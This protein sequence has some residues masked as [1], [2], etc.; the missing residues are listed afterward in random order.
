[1]VVLAALLFCALPVFGTDWSVAR[2]AHFE[3]YAQAGEENARWMLLGLE[4]LHAFVPEA[5]PPLQDHPPVRVLVFASPEEYEPYRIG[6]SSDAFYIGSE[7]RDTIVMARRGPGDLRVAAHEY[8][9]VVEHAAGRNLPPWLNEGLAEFFSTVRLEEAHR[10]SIDL[11]A[12]TRTLRTR[13]WLPVSEL[14]ALSADSVRASNRGVSDRF[15]AQSWALAE[16]LLFA[17]RY[18]PRFPDLLAAVSAGA[19]G[20]EAFAAIYGTPLEEVEGD[21]RVWIGHRRVTPLSIPPI[22][23]HVLTIETATV[24]PLAARSLLAE[25]LLATSRFDRAWEVYRELAAQAPANPD[26]SA[27]LAL[28]ELHN[29]HHADARRQWTRALENGI[30]DPEVCYRFALAAQNAELAVEDIRPALARAVELRPGFDDAL[31]QLGL[32]ETN[33]G[34]W[35]AGLRH[36]QAMRTIS[37]G[38]Q[39]AYWIATADALSQLGRRE[40]AKAAADVALAHASTPEERENARTLGVI[41]LTDMQVRFTR[42]AAG[43]WRLVTTRVPHDSPDGNP[44]VEPSDRIRRVEGRLR[45]IDCSGPAALFALDTPAGLVTVSV[46]DPRHVQMRNAPS[47][48]TCGPQPLPSVIAVYAASPAATATG[49]LR[50]LEFR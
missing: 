48:F 12:R 26:F 22:D 38:R 8:W 17:P 11:E 25:L 30:R 7:T 5:G 31:Y 3:V 45:E 43:N 21:L 13:S 33:G 39:F 50:G 37:P 36:L 1:M 18:A 20:A 40:E 35:A 28:I 4:R 42:D 46:P 44:F 41:A 14:L 34:E 2:S 9:H 10:L 32:L 29:G 27:A 47:E 24:S 23:P 15:Y 49:I 16:M 19:P 6:P